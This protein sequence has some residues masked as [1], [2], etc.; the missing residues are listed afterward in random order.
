MDLRAMRYLAEVVRHGGFARAAAHAHATQPTLSKAIAQLEQGY[1]AR[2]LERSRQGVRL[3]AAGEI[4]HRHALAMLAEQERLRGELD[5]LK[6]LR[7]GELRLGLPP[8]GSSELFAPLLARYRQQY[9]Q[10]DIRL[11]E[12]GS[13]RLE[14]AVLAGELDV[15]AALLPLGE[16][17]AHQ[18][19]CDEPM[20]ALLPAGHPRAGAR[21]FRLEWLAD[22]PLI[23]FEE[24]FT[25]NRLIR[26]ACARRGV[27]PRETVGSAQVEFILALVAAGSGAALLPRL[28][29]RGRALSGLHALPLAGGDLR[30]RLALAWRRGA[31]LPPAARAWLALAAAP[32]L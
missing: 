16:G 23:P 5:E 25:L 6:G 19:V 20:L 29:L 17:L 4:V 15:A 13:R 28:V 18:P 12:H 10:V 7:R 2:L 21:R 1:G 24:S 27:A 30:W 9:P 26:E 32:D 8:L 14:Q 3:T 31:E 22:T 11:L